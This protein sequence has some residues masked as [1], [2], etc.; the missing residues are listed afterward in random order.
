M[1]NLTFAF[2]KRNKTQSKCFINV[3][4]YGKTFHSML[5]IIQN[6]NIVQ[7][8]RPGKWKK[9]IILQKC[10]CCVLWLLF[11]NKIF[12]MQKKIYF[13]IPV[14][15]CMGDCCVSVSSDSQTPL[16]SHWSL[17]RLEHI[18][19]NL[20]CV[21]PPVDLALMVAEKFWMEISFEWIL[22]EFLAQ[23]TQSVGSSSSTSGFIIAS[24]CG[25]K[26]AQVT[27]ALWALIPSQKSLR[28]RRV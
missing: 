5:K 24:G 26:I 9:K 20:F 6:L 21:V 22:I 14:T 8:L 17:R 15:L 27:V 13:F 10:V 25:A 18:H 3:G 1:W 16:Y 12:L 19:H 4:M 2:L 11:V 23:L 28:S 7:D